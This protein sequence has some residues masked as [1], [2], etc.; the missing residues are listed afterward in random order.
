VAEKDPQFM[1][2]YKETQPVTE[3]NNEERMEK[4]AKP[5]FY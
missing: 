1:G 5:Y 3:F 2:A 4:R